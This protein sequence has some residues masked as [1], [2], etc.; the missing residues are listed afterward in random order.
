MP[1]IRYVTR[2]HFADYVLEDALE[3]EL[4]RLGIGRPL[5]ILDAAAAASDFW[6][7]LE[8]GLRAGGDPVFFELREP[9]P[10]VAA[11]GAA[12]ARYLARDCD[13]IV[14][15]GA[16]QA[17]DLAKVTGLRVSHGEELARYATAEGGAARIREEVPPTIAIPTTAGAGSEVHCCVKLRLEDGSRQTFAS[18]ALLPRVA[19]LDPSLVHGL[20]SETGAAQGACVLMRCFE[21]FLASPFNPPAEGLALDGLRRA[22]RAIDPFVE[23]DDLDA[24]REMMAA[25]LEGGLA[26]QKGVGIGHALVDALAGL[27]AEDGDPGRIAAVL[28]PSVL[29]FNRPAVGARWS[30]LESAIDAGPGTTLAASVRDRLRR[31]GLPRRLGQLGIDPGMIAL[32]AE[33]AESDCAYRTNPRRARV[34]ELREL[35]LALL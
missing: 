4:R 9:L 3:V 14:G 20:P 1:L 6:Y 19:I 17:I 15:F 27:A 2:I 33:R 13:G 35:M 25:A 12:A 28:L 18:R 21:T 32:A 23:S 11:C 5:V 24:R 22:W 34:E 31:L 10:T 26:S 8:R 7:R 16:P 29:E 30:Q